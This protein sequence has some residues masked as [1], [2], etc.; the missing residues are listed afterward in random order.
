MA[1]VDVQSVFSDVFHDRLLN[2][3]GWR[4]D[5]SD[6]C[7]LFATSSAV[8]S[9]APASADIGLHRPEQFLYS[10]CMPGSPASFVVLI[11]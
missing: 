9:M 3:P 8:G 11:Q 1:A 4:Y 7:A 5:A 6:F 2:S 10:G